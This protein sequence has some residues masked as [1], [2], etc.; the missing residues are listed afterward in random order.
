M[1]ESVFNGQGRV[2]ENEQ[3]DK[4]AR[5]LVFDKYTPRDSDDLID[6]SLTSL[7]VA[8]DLEL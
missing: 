2:V 1:G 3:E 8:V 7:P 5:K 4:H 6:W